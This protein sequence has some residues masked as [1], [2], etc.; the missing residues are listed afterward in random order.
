MYKEK[1]PW[2]IIYKISQKGGNLQLEGKFIQKDV[3]SINVQEQQPI[4]D[5]IVNLLESNKYNIHSY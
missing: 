3:V 4:P 2:P 5:V 1:R